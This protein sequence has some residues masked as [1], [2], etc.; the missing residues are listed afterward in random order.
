MIFCNYVRT[1][2]QSRPTD[3]FRTT[4]DGSG[5]IVSKPI[6]VK[7][8]NVHEHVHVNDH[9]NENVHVDGNRGH[10]GSGDPSA[11]E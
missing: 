4:S 1:A 9:V 5:E 2:L 8:V 3:A 11:H 10:G 7:A 6:F